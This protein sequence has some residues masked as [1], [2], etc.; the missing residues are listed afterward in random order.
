MK[1]ELKMKRVIKKE[2]N[3]KPD[4]SWNDG[5]SESGG[6]DVATEREIDLQ[7]VAEA[8]RRLAD[9]TDRVV[10]FKPAR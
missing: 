1:R 9:P 3:L 7:D 6:I 5:E 2:A 4:S 10:P 8:E